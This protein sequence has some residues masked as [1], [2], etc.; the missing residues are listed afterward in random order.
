MKPISIN[1][2]R[3]F[4]LFILS[5]AV[6][7]VHSQDKAIPDGT[8]YKSF[9]E[10]KKDSSQL[11]V[12]QLNPENKLL[13]RNERGNVYAMAPDNMYCLV[14]LNFSKMPVLQNKSGLPYMPNAI[15]RK[16]PLTAPLPSK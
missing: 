3:L 6:T 5:T 1:Y 4:F 11:P 8:I 7:V 9:Q 12:V 13:F 14:P 2:F 15:P 16:K 10:N